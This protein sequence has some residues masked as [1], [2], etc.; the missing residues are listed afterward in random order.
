MEGKLQFEEAGGESYKHVACLNDSDAW[1]TVMAN[2]I[3]TWQTSDK[4]PM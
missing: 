1:V 2:W 3:D 4:L